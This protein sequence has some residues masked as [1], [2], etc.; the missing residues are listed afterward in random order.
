MAISTK[1]ALLVFVLPLCGLIIV[2][3]VGFLVFGVLYI[4]VIAIFTSNWIFLLV[5]E[6]LKES[7]DKKLEYLDD[8]L[9]VNLYSELENGSLYW[10]LEGIEKAT[11]E[12]Q[13]HGKF[14]AIALYPKN[15]LKELKAFSQLHISFY[16][17]FEQLL[18]IANKGLESEADKWKFWCFLGF[19]GNY[20]SPSQEETLVY[21]TLVKTIR[22][23]HSQPLN[24]VMS[25]HERLIMERKRIFE[26]LEEFLKQNNLRLKPKPS[27]TGQYPY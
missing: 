4:E 27:G 2:D 19:G 21:T 18:K 6:R 1:L 24:E 3:I 16:N 13:R 17:K 9:F 5:W 22:E 12:L 15:L 20:S 26:E 7:L 14:M 8:N 10:K 23:K 11:N 25:L